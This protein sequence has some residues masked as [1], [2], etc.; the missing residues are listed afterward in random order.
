MRK[1]FLR[2]LKIELV[3]VY[4]VV[5]AGSVVRMSGSG[6]G[7]PDWPK[8]F[9]LLV[10]PTQTEQVIFHPNTEVAK[11]QMI[12][13]NDTL[14]KA[15]AAMVTGEEWD[16][17]VWKAYTV[18]DY[19][20]FN[21]LH[22]W[23]EYINRLLGALSGLP[24]ILI[25][26]VSLYYLRR[27]TLLTVLAFSALIM[28]GFEAWLGKLVV[29]GNLIPG[30]ITI[31]MLGAMVIIALILMMMALVQ[32]NVSGFLFDKKGLPAW[33]GV[34]LTLTLAQIIMG[35]QV[36]E[37]VDE[38]YK[39]HEGGQRG[40]WA[41]ELGITFYVHRSFSILLLLVNGY[42]W[43]KNRRL[44]KP[45]ALVTLMMLLVVLETIAGIILVYADFPPMLQPIHLVLAIILFGVQFFLW[46]HNQLARLKDPESEAFLAKQEYVSSSPALQSSMDQSDN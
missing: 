31:H 12:I 11:G 44:E 2:L 36:R 27:F 22:T 17:E 20:V 40:L 6:M 32:Q 28:L 37:Q 29:D 8:C 5:I 16:R 9:G 10:P 39:L 1:F 15:K 25:A 7:C 41:G 26:F 21:P 13:H 19:T 30:S 24:M 46:F 33:M 18:H 23:I 34:A 43:N 3:L 4:L 42:I 14:W 35:T 38:L 45:V